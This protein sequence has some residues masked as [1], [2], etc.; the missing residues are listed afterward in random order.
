L[1]HI[2]FDASATVTW[3]TAGWSGTTPT[4]TAVVL[5]VRY[6]STAVPDESWTAFTPVSGP[7]DAV[8]RYLQYRLQL[9]T[10]DTT[11]TPVVNDVTLNISR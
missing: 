7:I 6:G 2:G 9:S 11:Q 1:H 10:T 3:T 8:G 5:S 4:G